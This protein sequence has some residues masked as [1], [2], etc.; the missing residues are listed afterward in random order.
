MA[1]LLAAAIWLPQGGVVLILLFVSTLALWEFYALLDASNIPHFK[2][3]GLASGMALILSTWLSL[4]RTSG[5]P[6]ESDWVVLSIV[7]AL[8]FL[9][10]FPQKNNPRP[11]E[12]MAG[13]LLGIM[14]VPFLFNFFT[15]ILVVWSGNEG[16]LLALYAIFI[17]KAADVGAYFIGCAVGRHKLF[18]RISPKKTWEGFGGGLLTGTVVSVVFF[19]LA[20]RH[21]TSL[22]L[23]LG[24]AVGIG[25][26]LGVLGTMGDLTES[27][28]KRAAGVKDSGRL[29]LGMGGLLDVVDSLLFAAPAMYMYARFLMR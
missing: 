1:A 11:L 16:R 14:Y 3:L 9:R 22:D 23:G 13:T 6:W 27:L 20:R 25:I 7:T 24:D 4:G 5:R 10:Q 21:M 18:P 8:V 19:L 28:F 12:T 2:L 15:R 29:I 17:V 26:L